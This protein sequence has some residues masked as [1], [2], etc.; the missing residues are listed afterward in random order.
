MAKI[1]ANEK[2]E[3]NSESINPGVVSSEKKYFSI[4]ALANYSAKTLNKSF[5]KDKLII[6]SDPDVVSFCQSNGYFEVKAVSEEEANSIMR[7]AANNRR[8][9]IQ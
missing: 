1:N 5:V 7:P 3:D 2:S 8:K 6:S 9:R 4:K